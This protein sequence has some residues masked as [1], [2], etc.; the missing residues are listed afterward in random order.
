MLYTP[1]NLRYCYLGV[2]S[3]ILR[4]WELIVGSHHW[5][6]WLTIGIKWWKQKV[7][8]EDWKTTATWCPPKKDKAVKQ[9]AA[10][11]WG[12]RDCSPGDTGLGSNPTCAPNCWPSLGFLTVNSKKS[13]IYRSCLNVSWLEPGEKLVHYSVSEELLWLIISWVHISP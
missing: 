4:L 2:A 3:M 7:M 13:I 8:A 11:I 12:L 10:L 1:K 5:E 9:W 6:T